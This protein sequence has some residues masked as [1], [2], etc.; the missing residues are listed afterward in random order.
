MRLKN[1]ILDN[2]ILVTALLVI[3]IILLFIIGLESRK[4]NEYK[5][6]YGESSYKYDSLMNLTFFRSQEQ[7]EYFGKSEDSILAFLPTPTFKPVVLDLQ[8]DTIPLSRICNLQCS[9]SGMNNPY[10]KN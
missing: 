8:S 4:I 3:I 2:K 1:N 9:P 6:L 10:N 5:Y 7:C